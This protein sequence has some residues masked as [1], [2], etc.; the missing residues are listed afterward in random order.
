MAYFSYFGG[1]N[2]ISGYIYS[3]IPQDILNNTKTFTEVF[4]GAFWTYMNEDWSFVDKV[5]YN[6]MNIYITNLMYCTTL[7][8]F[9]PL[10]EKE[11]EKGGFFHFD[12]NFKNDKDCYD[13][14]YQRFRTTFY[15]IRKELYDDTEGQEI[16][17]DMPDFNMAI[18]YAFLLRHAFSGIP[19]KKAGYSY[20]ASSYKEGKKL[21]EPKSQILLRKLKDKSITEKLSKVEFEAVDFEEHIKKHDSPKTMFYVDPPY[22]NKEKNYFRGDEYFGDSG[23]KRLADV[24]SKIQ[25]KFILSYYDFDDLSDFYPKDKYHWR[26]KSFTKATTSIVKDDKIDK[27]GYELLIMNFKPKT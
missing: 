5:V 17:F 22:K 19:G 25:G 27:K 18:K 24:L 23:H 4:S 2:K 9:L 14:N 20:S 3:Q 21:P 12:R 13:V 7:P 1:K 15:D 16:K 8:E 26:E 11:Y 6:D 10:I